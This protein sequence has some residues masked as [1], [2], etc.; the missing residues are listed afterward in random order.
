[1]NTLAWA[2]DVLKDVQDAVDREAQR[3][4]IAAKF[5][6]LPQ[7]VITTGTTT[8]LSD[9]ISQDDD[10]LKVDEGATTSLYQI[11]VKFK[12]SDSQYADP[13][14]PKTAITLATR[15]ANLLSQAEDILIF[16]GK[17]GECNLIFSSKKVSIQQVGNPSPGLLQLDSIA[18]DQVIKVIPTNE[19]SPNDPS[20]NR[21]GENTF[22]A[23]A[24]GYTRLQ[25]RGHYGPYALVLH[26]RIY[27]D[28][29]APLAATLIMPA[30]RIKSL[31]AFKDINN[32]VNEMFYGTG[33][34]PI[35]DGPIPTGL[36]VSLGGNTMD[37]VIKTPPTVMQ[38]PQ[39]NTFHPFQVTAQFAV[40]LKDVSSS[41]RFEFQPNP[42]KT[43]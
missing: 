26:D 7:N 16:Q 24:E 25:D 5:L 27:A 34:L 40:R 23:V 14:G 12:L 35:L 33:T 28:T 3:I 19:P 1:M 32:T 6:P 22:A 41:I 4:K 17:K 31:V 8:V 9:I 10:S 42:T 2:D 36:L 37:L 11:T 30:D 15:A 21:Y 43:Y 39:E 18:S 13:G 20:Q 38:L 29:Y